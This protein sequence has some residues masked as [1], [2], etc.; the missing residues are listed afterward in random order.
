MLHASALAKGEE[1][2]CVGGTK[3]LMLLRLM[4]W[5]YVLQGLPDSKPTTPFRMANGWSVH[6]GEKL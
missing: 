4:K 2:F 6:Y 3:I 5:R 1:L